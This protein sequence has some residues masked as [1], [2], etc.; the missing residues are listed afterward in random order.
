MLG[1]SDGGG[2]REL[3]RRT[4][5][6]AGAGPNL[7]AGLNTYTDV[8]IYGDWHDPAGQPH[9]DNARSRG[10]LEP[11]VTVRREG[12]KLILGFTGT[13]RG[14]YGDGLDVQRPYSW[15][16]HEYVLDD[17]PVIRLRLG[18]R[19]HSSL[20]PGELKAFAAHYTDLPAATAWRAAGVDGVAQ[21][22][23][24]ST[25]RDR[26]WQSKQ[27]GG[28]APGGFRFTD[29]GGWLDV[30]VTGGEALQNAFLCDN[31]GQLALFLAPFDLEP[32]T[33]TPRW[34]ETEVA[35]EVGP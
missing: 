8:G 29:A 15:Y 3:R 20:P 27:H 6:G 31:G 16:R 24:K 32:A 18:F 14:S 35:L 5:A 10:D 1:R 9:R 4:A 22:P 28:L 12:T 33:V 26:V 23:A 30:Q 25:S 2:I 21:Q 7:F 19:P 13:F 34:Y 17:S 11:D